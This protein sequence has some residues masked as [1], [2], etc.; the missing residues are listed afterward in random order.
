[1]EVQSLHAGIE[2][3]TVAERTGF[4]LLFAEPLLSTPAPTQEELRILRDE[5]DPY[6]YVIGR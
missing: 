4:E 3:A 5:V 6:R 2:Q 1:M